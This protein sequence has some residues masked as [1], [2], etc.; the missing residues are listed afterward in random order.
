VLEALR[1]VDGVQIFDEDTP[2][3]LLGRLRPDIWVKGA[4][5]TGRPLP[6]RDTVERFGGQVVLLPVVPGYSTTRLVSASRHAA[7]TALTQEA[8]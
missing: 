6:E 1:W 5:Y 7:G 3:E 4:D 2:R 8:R